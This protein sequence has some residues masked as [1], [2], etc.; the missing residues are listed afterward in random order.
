MYYSYNEKILNIYKNNNFQTK[1]IS[2]KI[3]LSHVRMLFK[4]FNLNI[5]NFIRDFYIIRILLGS[6]PLK[7][8]R[9]AMS[10][11]FCGSSGH[12]SIIY[13]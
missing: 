9:L 1:I 2:D 12:F 13:L 7:H 4:E 3:R 5:K 6:K 10:R 11:R 8:F